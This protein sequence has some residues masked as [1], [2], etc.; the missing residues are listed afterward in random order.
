[1]PNTQRHSRIAGW[2][3][4][5]AA[6]GFMI[7]FSYLAARFGYPDVLDGQA[8]DVLPSL[9]SLGAMGRIV[10]GAYAVLPLL[11]IPASIAAYELLAP[12]SPRVMRVA[13][14][15]GVIAAIAM[16]LGL[17]RWPTL[18]WALAESWTTASAIDRASIA[19]RFAAL[20]LYLGNFTGELLGE[21]ALNTF[22]ALAG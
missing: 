3:L 17:V 11:L 13:R 6:V 16:F 14:A 19:D 7:A 22:F 10:W 20:N 8:G 1:M 4:I 15:A 12:S 21:I 18:Q 9:L 5:L 2:S